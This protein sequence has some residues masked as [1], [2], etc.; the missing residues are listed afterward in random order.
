MRRRGGCAMSVRSRLRA[1]MIRR[2][3]LC[4]GALI[5]EGVVAPSIAPKRGA[6]FLTAKKHIPLSRFATLVH[7][8]IGLCMLLT[9]IHP[10]PSTTT[11][12]LL[13]AGA[14]VVRVLALASARQSAPLDAR[15]KKN[16][17]I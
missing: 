12:F 9:V 5:R 8:L 17:H 13:S 15:Q 4:T 6:Q 3:P 2:L 10:L 16:T 7:T 11:H 14:V 1:S